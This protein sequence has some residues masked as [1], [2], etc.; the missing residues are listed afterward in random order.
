MKANESIWHALTAGIDT[1]AK[2]KKLWY[3]IL[4]G[5]LAYKAITLGRIRKF[6]GSTQFLILYHDGKKC[7][8]EWILK[9]QLLERR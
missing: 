2:R 7:C 6:L 9:S 8:I 4:P 1:K 3:E 5:A